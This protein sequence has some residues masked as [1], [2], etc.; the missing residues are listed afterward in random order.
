MPYTN[1]LNTTQFIRK[2]RRAGRHNG[3]TVVFD[4]KR[5]KGSHGTL[6]YGAR[7]TVVP[8]SKDLGAGLVAA[9]LAQIGLTVADI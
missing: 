5:G 8:R 6:Y 4:A 2:V 1:P 9:M 3:V 7:W